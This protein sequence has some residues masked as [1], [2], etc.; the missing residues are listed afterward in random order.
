LSRAIVKLY[1]YARVADAMRRIIAS[2]DSYRV[3]LPTI[4]KRYLEEEEKKKKKKKNAQPPRDLPRHDSF[5]SLDATR[6]PCA[7]LR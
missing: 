4:E 2:A 7:R 6:W 1:R 5:T 3:K